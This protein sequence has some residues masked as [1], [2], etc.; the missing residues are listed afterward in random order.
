MEGKERLSRERGR[1][2]PVPLMG[3]LGNSCS[4]NDLP[5]NGH[6]RLHVRQTDERTEIERQRRKKDTNKGEIKRK[7]IKGD[8][9][10]VSILPCSV[11]S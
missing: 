5:T 8:S 7:K 11:L 4:C 1:D 3:S 6:L 9:T 10:G 2:G